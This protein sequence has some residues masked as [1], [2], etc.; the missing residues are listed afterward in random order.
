MATAS[1]R[2]NLERFLQGI[3]LFRGCDP[4][5]VARVAPHAEVLEYPAKAVILRAGASTDG[6]VVLLRGR[7]LKQYVNAATGATTTVEAL[8]PGDHA[9]ELGA[10]LKVAQPHGLVA[11]EA[12][13]VVRIR[14]DI[15]ESL[16]QRVPAFTL[17]V[18]RRLAT[19]NVQLGVSA[20]RAPTAPSASMVPAVSPDKVTPQS[21]RAA[22][23]I[24]Y[25]EVADYEPTP[26]VISLIPARLILQHRLL[27]LRLQGDVLTVGMV[28]PR[29]AG[30]LT[31]L[32]Q[33]LQKL[34]LEVV[35]IGL[36][37]FQQAVVRHRIEVVRGGDARGDAK[38]AP[39]SLSFDVTDSERDPDK[40]LR[41]VG[42]EV[43]R[44]VNRIVAAAVAREASDVHI[45][46]ELAGVRV[47]FRVQGVLSDWGEQIPPSYGKGIAARV[48]VLAGLDITDRRLPQEGRIGLSAGTREIDLRVSTMP[49]SRGEKVAMRIFEA[50]GMTRSLE[51]LF[52][53]PG[54]LAV[55]RRAI[56]RPF[57]LTVIAGGGGAGKSTTL[58]AMLQERRRQ[59]PDSSMLMV[60]DPIEY[61]MQGVTQVQVNADIGL[62]FAQVLR[63]AMR[64]DPDVVC[65][66]ETRDAE[67]AQLVLESSMT[68]H[69][70]FT[71]MHANDSMAVLQRLESLG[72]G[73]TL[74]AQGLSAV[75]VQRLLRRLCGACARLE[76]PP[77]ALVDALAARG[78]V[79]RGAS[80][81][82]PRAVGCD[83]CQQT[84]YAGRVAVVETLQLTDE[85][86]DALMA[87][88]A[89]ASVEQTARARKL[90]APF[91]GYAASLMARK[92]V[93]ASEA[94]LAV[95]D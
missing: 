72:C 43:V 11:D 74:V 78:L 18:A 10:L 90:L 7:A 66:G 50:A 38:V 27:P 79:E 40:A 95:M 35:A 58:Y 88:E 44:C 8:A 75:I 41:I 5:V 39:E 68:G 22:G 67:T 76:A 64:Q 60:E 19:R 55:A 15:V 93:A 54:A 1:E 46:P 53:E 94:L 57:G 87:G 2:E 12:C 63:A 92:M 47:R 21:P 36:E 25:V 42:D 56:Q 59:R 4:T 26:R 20:L 23:V 37:D 83:A 70:M 24:P 80:S 77:P 34:E 3:G 91:A 31:E 61:R 82:L 29:Y 52:V 71:S 9:G 62:G 33:L 14:G 73:R 81:L 65:V 51:Q 49:G 45:E 13:A 69:L 17:N 86:R 6:M 30:L 32:H 48:K 85:L 28:T 84:G 89:L 16:L